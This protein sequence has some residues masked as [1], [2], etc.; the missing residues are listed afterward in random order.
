MAP[1]T[2]LVSVKIADD[3][4]NASEADLLRGL[5]WVFM[6]RGGYH[7]Q[8][9]NLSVSV[10]IPESYANS[11]VDAA[12]ER[13]WRESVSVVAAAGNLGSADD[14]MWYAPG[15]DPRIITVGCLDE[16]QTTTS[17]DDSLC[18]ISSRGVTEDGFAKPD[19]V[20][21]GRKIVSALAA[22][23]EGHGVT[24]GTEFPDRITPDGRHIRLSGTSMAAPIVTGAIALLLERQPGMHPD[25]VKELLLMTSHAYPG[26]S[27][28][29]GML[30][31]ARA[32][33]GATTPPNHPQVLVPVAGITPPGGA[34]SLL[35]D[36][37]HWASSY[38]DGARWGSTYLDGARWGAA[39]WDGARWGSAYWDG[40]RWGSAYWDGARWGSANLDGARWGSTADW[41][42]ARWGDAGRYD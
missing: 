33:Q 27:D 42:G 20:A 32:M 7:I 23:P 41:D 39:T 37:S 21:P 15:N 31:V 34:I 36:G 1:N 40:A 25:Q 2:T 4:G 14:A 17:S 38:F 5:D 19:L 13:L 6:N 26:Q 9:L 29:A 3:Q 28:G 12:V 30:D 35:W 10:G 24:L 16:N 8:A 18:P 22:G 11:P